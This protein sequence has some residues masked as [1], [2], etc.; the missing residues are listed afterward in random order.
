M[1]FLLFQCKEHVEAHNTIMMYQHQWERI[2]RLLVVQFPHKLGWKVK[3][4]ADK[5]K[6]LCSTYSKM[7]KLQNQA[8]GGARDNNAKFIWYDEIN[9]ILSLTA[10][11]NGVPGR[12]DQGVP[13]PGMGSSSVPIDVSPEHDGDGEPAW[14]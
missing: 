9:E 10:K 5:W 11:T 12:M 13:V 6:N 7:K 4:L 1:R 14:T 8:G 2:H 3:S